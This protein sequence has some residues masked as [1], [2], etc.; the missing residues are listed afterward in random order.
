MQYSRTRPKLG[1]AQMTPMHR[2]MLG[3]CSCERAS[4][5]LFQ[6]STPELLAILAATMLPWYSA[7]YVT[8]ADPEPIFRRKMSSSNSMTIDSVVVRRSKARV[9]WS[10][11]SPASPPSTSMSSRLARGER[12]IMELWLAAFAALRASS[13]AARAASL[14]SRI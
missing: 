2:M 1:V 3:C 12:S 8:P 6:S 14:A 5:S 11:S 4:T 9:P 10:E 7:R 13:S